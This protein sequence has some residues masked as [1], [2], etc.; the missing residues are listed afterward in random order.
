MHCLELLLHVCSLTSELV[1]LGTWRTVCLVWGT[2]FLFLDHRAGTCRQLGRLATSVRR[3]GFPVPGVLCQR[4]QASWW[5]RQEVQRNAKK[6][7]MLFESAEKCADS[8]ETPDSGLL[9]SLFLVSLWWSAQVHHWVVTVAC[10]LA[11]FAPKALGMN[12]MDQRAWTFSEH[13]QGFGLFIAGTFVL[14]VASEYNGGMTNHDWTGKTLEKL[15]AQKTLMPEV[16]TSEGF[17][18]LGTRNLLHEKIIVQKPPTRCLL[19]HQRQFFWRA[20]LA[21]CQPFLYMLRLIHCFIIT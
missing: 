21:S 19:H 14:D 2:S 12:Q 13:L 15:F 18:M 16:F 7:N 4:L 8:I 17:E 1:R 5:R 20:E 10:V 11:L 6:C 9:G 3:L